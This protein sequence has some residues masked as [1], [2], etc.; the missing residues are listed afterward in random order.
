MTKKGQGP[1]FDKPFGRILWKASFARIYKDANILLDLAK[2]SVVEGHTS[3]TRL[4]RISILS[5]AI[6]LEALANRLLEDA[7]ESTGEEITDERKTSLKDKYQSII[8]KHPAKTG[9]KFSPTKETQKIWNMFIEL[10][11]WRDEFV[12]PKGFN[13]VIYGLS[14]N[15]DGIKEI[16]AMR[17]SQVP[18]VLKTVLC[19][20]VPRYNFGLSGLPTSPTEVVLDNALAAKSIVDK[21]VK[22]LNTVLGGYLT[23]NK[24]LDEI[25]I[26]EF[27][28]PPNGERQIVELIRG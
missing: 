5:F 13:P 20:R 4:P 10:I 7:K 11:H 25:D 16:N 15:R 8:E 14:K 6:S 18:N 27:Y 17:R 22:R 12:H 19:D 28:F 2:S 24:L 26:G 23:E 21:F 1:K 3:I 9:K